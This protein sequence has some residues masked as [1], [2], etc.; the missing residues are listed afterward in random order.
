MLVGKVN[1]ALRLL[2]ESEKGG[3]MPLTSNLL[4]ILKLKHPPAESA[5]PSALLSGPVVQINPIL[6]AGLQGDTIRAAA[7]R[8]QGSA[9]PSGGDAD[10]WRQ[11]CTAFGQASSNLCSAMANVSRR[12]ATSFLD[13]RG[14]DALLANRRIPLDKNPG[15]RPI[16]IGE[17]PRRIIAKAIIRLL[18]EDIQDAA[19][20][21]QLCAGQESGCEAIIQAFKKIF[22]GDDTDAILLVDA[23]N[24]FN[25][26]NRSVALANIER[27]C[28]PLAKFTIN[29]YRHPT[30]LF[31]TGGAELAS[32]EG[33]TQGDPLAMPLYALSIIP[34]IQRLHGICTQ[35]WY[36]DDAQACGK[37][38]ALRV[39]WNTIVS[40][41]PAYGYYANPIKT[42]LVIKEHM[43]DEAKQI[44]NGTG[45]CITV[46]SR[47]LGAAIGSASFVNKYVEDKVQS[48]AKELEML[49]QIAQASPQAAHSAFVH[50]MRHK[51]TFLQ[52]TL[53]N[54]SEKFQ[55]L[56]DIIRAK[57]IPSLL[58]GQQVNDDLREWMALSGK[59]G[60]LAIENP[61]HDS[62][63]K[64]TSSSL[65]CNSLVCHIIQ[66]NPNFHTNK[67]RQQEIRNQN[68]ATKFAAEKTAMESLKS[69]ISPEQIRTME[70]CHEKGS[71]ALIT[72]LPLK[73]YGFALSRTQF[74]DTILM[75]YR[76]PLSDLPSTCVCGTSFSVDHSQICHLGGFIN[77]RHDEVK[78]L[79][80][81][82]LSEVL[83][84]V[85]SEPRLKPLTPMDTLNNRSANT[86]SDSRSDIRARGFWSDQTDAFFDIRVYY[87]HA[88][89]YMT[90][91]LP[92]LYR[93]FEQQKK[94]QYSERIINID[95]GSF[96]PLVFSTF[97]G[98]G[99]EANR[100]IK[101]L[102][103]M[104]AEKKNESYSHVVGLLRA[105]LTFALCRSANI[106]LRGTRRRR[107]IPMVNHTP[108]DVINFQ[109][110]IL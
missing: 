52:R 22:A 42:K 43:L 2:T 50:G 17:T 19:G 57:F 64:F 82:G 10:Q 9:G 24:A 7:I 87:P 29:C 90:R 65:L 59:N 28:P 47:D 41:G 23:D 38:T 40:D 100:T 1:A 98:M 89:S 94:N 84:D 3:L 58:G 91:N 44:F 51:W 11:M 15:V 85:E 92:S 103:A 37:L 39:W 106:C 88:S 83:H 97:G 95:H 60:G 107:S 86:D 108:S 21:L 68:R 14:L 48:W 34:L 102:A 27:I 12:M 73:K 45:I 81:K 72:T 56:E 30:R 93:T 16:G 55:P 99:E 67:E 6:F 49:A 25:R 109:S 46:G 26:L 69:R 105:Q 62:C 4:D 63:T 5:T 96:T 104:L 74:Q 13:P 36:A 53:P 31:V 110:N 80:A 75:R 76:L 71:S 54:I 8:T 18:R 61:V 33:T 35:A 32:C 20:S 70:A 66:Q 101:K 77:Q 78:N 79:L